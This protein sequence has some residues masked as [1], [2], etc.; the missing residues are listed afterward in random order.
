MAASAVAAPAIAQST[1][2]IRWRLTA[3]WPKSLDTLMRIVDF[4]SIVFADSTGVLVKAGTG[5]IDFE[6]VAGKRNGVVP[7][8]TNIQAIRDQLK[9]RRLDATL[10]EFS[11][12]D[13]GF[14]ALA[15]ASRKLRNRNVR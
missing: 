13:A 7:G 9:R 14:A 5:I 11:N 6:S 4:S 10:V 15:S 3:S 8:T 2:T 12:R 1:P